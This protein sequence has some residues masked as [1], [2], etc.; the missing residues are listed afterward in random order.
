MITKIWLYGGPTDP[1]NVTIDIPTRIARQATSL[2]YCGRACSDPDDYG[3]THGYYDEDSSFLY[4]IRHRMS[5]DHLLFRYTGPCTLPIVVKH[6]FS[7]TIDEVVQ[8]RENVCEQLGAK[9][10]TMDIGEVAFRFT[11]ID[12]G[13]IVQTRLH[14]VDLLVLPNDHQ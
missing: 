12:D 4:K 10:D 3:L 5:E 6:R 8:L 1:I 13:V 7:H 9:P 14:I 11:D 2:A